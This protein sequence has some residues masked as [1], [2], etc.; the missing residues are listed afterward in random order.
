MIS[1]NQ[2][3]IYKGKTCKPSFSARIRLLI[4]NIFII[5]INFLHLNTND[6]FLDPTQLYFLVHQWICPIKCFVEDPLQNFSL[7]FRT[8]V[9]PD[10]SFLWTP[11]WWIDQN[12]LKTGYIRSNMAS[13]NK[14]LIKSKPFFFNFWNRGDEFW[15]ER[16]V[17]F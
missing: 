17:D 5:I 1:T 13:N 3:R 8:W 12:F 6:R 10:F 11:V 14:F 15:K 9:F 2:I 7:L 16:K 4:Y